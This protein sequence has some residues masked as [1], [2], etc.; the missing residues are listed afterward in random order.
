MARCGSTFGTQM[1]E[2]HGLPNALARWFSS[3]EMN[4]KIIKYIFARQYWL[5]ETTK[6]EWHFGRISKMS[7]RSWFRKRVKEITFK[8]NGQTTDVS[9]FFR[10]ERIRNLTNFIYSGTSINRTSRDYLIIESYC[11]SLIRIWGGWPWN[12]N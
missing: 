6:F 9:I 5:D 11:D 4:R 2:F 3:F 10:K 1:V 8:A 12:S 7:S